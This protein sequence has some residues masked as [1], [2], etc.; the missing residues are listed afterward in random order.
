MLLTTVGPSCC[1]HFL[2]YTAWV[3]TSL[4]LD[5]GEVSGELNHDKCQ[6]P[7]WSVAQ[8]CS[9]GILIDSLLNTDSLRSLLVGSRHT[10]EGGGAS[11]VITVYF[12]AII[13]SPLKVKFV[14][15]TSSL[16]PF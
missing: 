8:T 12:K 14:V 1:N 13:L 3:T 6:E 2:L 16:S 9:P 7:S 10:L 11:A 15:L 5:Y 4:T